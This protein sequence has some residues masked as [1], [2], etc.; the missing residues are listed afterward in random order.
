M[1]LFLY[2]DGKFCYEEDAHI[3]IN[4]RGYQ[5]GDSVYEVILYKNGYFLDMIGHI[6]R[7]RK[8]LLRIDFNLEISDK[9]IEVIM[10]R[11]MKENKIT[12][13]SVYI[14][15]SRGSFARDHS[16]IN[17]RLK[18]VLLIIP[19]K[20]KDRFS[21][22][23]KG[24]KVCTTKDTRW[25]YPDIKTTQLLPNVMAKSMAIKRGFDEAIFIDKNKL[26]TEGSSSNFWI[27]D[28][29][30][31]L[32]TRSLDGKILAGI[33]RDSILKCAK[34]NNINVVEKKI[35]MTDVKSSLEVFI[36]SASSFVTPVI[37]VDDI[38]INKG[39]VGKVSMLL[40]KSYLNYTA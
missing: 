8:S 32:V 40:R 4:D 16:Y 24:I 39:K 22:K 20:I 36:T 29:N 18:P 34:N 35:S 9:A 25:S 30:N 23:I 13:G 5:F 26:I 37:Q 7:L 6:K 1:S 3:S 19:K 12:Y 11:L 17:M 15:V 28:K 10:H 27:L 2:L 38:K 14:Q 21:S 33:T 31:N